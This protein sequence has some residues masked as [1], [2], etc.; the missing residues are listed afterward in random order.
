MIEY[1]SVSFGKMSQKEFESYVSKQL[2]WI[3][4]N[5]IGAFFSSDTYSNIVATI[6]QEYKKF[7]SK[8]V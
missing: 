6:E 2:P 7:L 4:E 8:L 3:Y 1:H 5:I